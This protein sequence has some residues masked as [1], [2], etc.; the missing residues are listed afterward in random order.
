MNPQLLQEA[1][2]KN[3]G[4][5]KC[6]ESAWS[7]H[8]SY[9][10]FSRFM[11]FTSRNYFTKSSSAAGCSQHQQQTSG[12]SCSWQWLCYM[13]KC[14]CG[15]VLVLQSQRLVF[16]AADHD[17]VNLLYSL[18]NGFFFCHHNIWKEVKNESKLPKNEPG[19]IS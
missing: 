18:Q 19:N 1:F 17:F 5:Q 7:W 8:F 11:I 6:L 9:L 16:L 4:R 3:G 14:T 10:I 13:S 12:G 2:M 15:E